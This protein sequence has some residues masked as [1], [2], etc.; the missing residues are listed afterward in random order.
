MLTE[1]IVSDFKKEYSSI[2]IRFQRNNGK[3]HD[4]Y[5]VIDYNTENETIYHCGASSKD[6]GD[7]ITTILTIE[8]TAIYHQIFDELLKNPRLDL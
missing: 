7:K 6:A 3:Y 5:L 2:M 4:R 1:S 8:N